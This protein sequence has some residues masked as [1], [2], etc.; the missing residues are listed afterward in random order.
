MNP[1]QAAQ[2]A[3]RLRTDIRQHRSGIVRGTVELRHLAGLNDTC[4]TL[5]SIANSLAEQHADAPSRK[6]LR[7]VA[8]RALELG[9]LYAQLERMLEELSGVPPGRRQR[10]LYDELAGRQKRALA[11][12]RKFEPVLDEFIRWAT[13][14]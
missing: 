5:E 14:H 11:K 9:L 3:K 8:S 12:S 6:L 2:H 10:D 7:A 4:I 1:G 13:T